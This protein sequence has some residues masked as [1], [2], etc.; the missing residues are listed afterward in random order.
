MVKE[1][2]SRTKQ[3]GASIS[4]GVAHPLLSASLSIT[5][6]DPLSGP[7]GGCWHHLLR[8]TANVFPETPSHTLLA[9]ALFTSSVQ[10]SLAPSRAG[11]CSPS[12]E[13]PVELSFCVSMITLCQEPRGAGSVLCSA[14]SPAS[15]TEQGLLDP[16]GPSLGGEARE[17]LLCVAHLLGVLGPLSP[18]AALKLLLPDAPGD[19]LWTEITVRPWENSSLWMGS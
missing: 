8:F 2:C 14:C 1:L 17:R 10:P 7:C 3:R 9:S 16:C 5:P 15:G 18:C 19:K 6:L 11:H 4:K 13:L 12:P